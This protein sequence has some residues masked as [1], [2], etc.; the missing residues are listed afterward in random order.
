[1]K[2]YNK[3]NS[4]QDMMV[5]EIRIQMKMLLILTINLTFYQFKTGCQN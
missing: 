3:K 5:I 1:M 4:I 2:I